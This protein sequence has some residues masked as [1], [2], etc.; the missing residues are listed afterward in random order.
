VS[1]TATSPLK[2]SGRPLLDFAG[3]AE[4]TG[5]KESHL[6]RLVAEKRIPRIKMGA[7]RTSPVRFDPDKLDEWITSLNVDPESA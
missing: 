6:R 7:G 2:R 5:L 4:Y 1:K 3:A